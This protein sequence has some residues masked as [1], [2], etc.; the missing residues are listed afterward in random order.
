[1]TSL[2]TILGALPIAISL[3]AAATSRKPLG[4]VIVGGLFFSLI[5]TLFVIPAIYTYVSGKHKK[6]EEL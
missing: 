5:L 6:M 1:M 4:T 3:G 2:A